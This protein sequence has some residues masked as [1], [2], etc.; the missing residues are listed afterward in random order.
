MSNILK[1]YYCKKKYRVHLAY[2]ILY[3]KPNE[4]LIVDFFKG[5]TTTIKFFGCH[6][7]LDK[8]NIACSGYK[9]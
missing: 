9:K 5:K 4:S 6:K 1:L 3:S 7:N 2:I 8:Q